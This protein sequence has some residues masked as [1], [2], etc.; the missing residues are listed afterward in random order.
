MTFHNILFCK[1]FVTNENIS[2]KIL[3]L[4]DLSVHYAMT[5]ESLKDVTSHDIG[6]KLFFCRSFINKRKH[7]DKNFAIA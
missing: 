3:Q 4:R 1:S 6:D 7:I 2:I 5:L